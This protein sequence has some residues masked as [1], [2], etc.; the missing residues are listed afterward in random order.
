[1]WRNQYALRPV[2]NPVVEGGMGCGTVY[3]SCWSGSRARAVSIKRGSRRRNGTGRLWRIPELSVLVSVALL[4]S[5]QLALAQFSHQQKL[6]GTGAIGNA[7]EGMSVSVSSDGNTATAIV[8]GPYDDGDKGAVWV[9]TRSGGVWTQQDKLVGTGAIG[10]ALLGGSVSLS[11]DGNTA[12]VGGP[13]DDDGKGAVWVYTRSGAVWTQQQKLVTTN[14]TIQQ[15]IPVSLSSD[16]NTAIVGGPLDGGDKGA[17]WVYTRSGASWTQ[18]SKLVDTAPNAQLGGSVSLSS[19]GNTAILGEA[20][21]NGGKGAAWVYTRS[22]GAWTQQQKLVGTGAIG[23]ALQGVSVSLSSDGNTAIVGAKG[24]DGG[25]GAAWVY[26]RSGGA[27]TQQGKLVG[28][29]AIGDSWQGYS[30]SLSADGNTAIVGGPFDDEE[31]GAAWVY[32]RSGGAW[33]QLGSKLVDTGAMWAQQGKSVSVS[34]DGNTAIVGGP[35]DNGDKGAAWVYVREIHLQARPW[36]WKYVAIDPMALILT[37]KALDIWF[38]IQHPHVPKVAEIQQVLRSMTP[39]EQK[40]ALNRARTLENYAK[41]E[42]K[43][44]RSMPQEEQKAALNRVRTLQ[45]YSK[46]VEEAFATIKK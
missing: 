22:G 34:S 13:Y 35:R 41:A 17:A 27:W 45:N 6:L 3:P 28:T 11:S 38:E 21:D 12:I 39:E 42:E 2:F 23:N 44:L 16:G 5:S 32:T 9:Y 46:A 20:L 26:T 43:M 18:Q 24:D 30:V 7:G 14:P 25:K 4:F 37:G 36:W 15:R 19:D 31:K 33:T 29:G 1:M 40:A 8:G 10:I